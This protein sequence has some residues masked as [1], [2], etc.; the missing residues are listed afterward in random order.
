MQRI[1]LLGLL[2]LASLPVSIFAQTPAVENIRFEN[3]MQ[4]AY[5]R[6]VNTSNKDITG[7]VLSVDALYEDSHIEHSLL[8]TDYV[9]AMLDRKNAGQPES[10]AALRAGDKKEVRLDL[11][12]RDGKWP[13]VTLQIKMTVIAYANATVDVQND[14][15]NGLGNLIAWRK[16]AALASRKAAEAINEAAADSVTPDPN[17]VAISKL[18]ALVLDQAQ[19]KAGETHDSAEMALIINRLESM[20]SASKTEL[21]H[22]A[23]EK[24]NDAA[25]L[26]MHAQLKRNQ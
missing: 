16:K 17:G 11:P 5:V 1:Y 6:I 10:M 24:Y 23:T 9:P 13:T 25:Y 15:E 7:F 26:E 2:A 21:R 19:R 8:L 22:Y 20:G 12:A 14:H 3:G 18:R 4:T